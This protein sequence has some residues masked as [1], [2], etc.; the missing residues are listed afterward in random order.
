VR[1]NSDAAGEAEVACHDLHPLAV[2]VDDAALIAAQTITEICLLPVVRALEAK[3]I[4]HVEL[5]RPD[6]SDSG[7]APQQRI[8]NGLCRC[9]RA[10]RRLIEDLHEVIA[11]LRA[12][13]D[14]ESLRAAL[15]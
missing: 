2:V 13:R 12:A 8:A 15:G 6:G 9:K 10:R 5:T 1:T 11:P 7:R 3:L 4:H 14:K